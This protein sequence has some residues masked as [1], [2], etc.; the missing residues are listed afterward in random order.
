MCTQYIHASA[1]THTQCRTREPSDI[2]SDGAQYGREQCQHEMESCHLMWS[3]QNTLK[4]KWMRKGEKRTDVPSC[5]ETLRRVYYYF[6]R[7]SY[8]AF[9]LS[10][11]FSNQTECAALLLLWHFVLVFFFLLFSFFHQIS[12]C[13]VQSFAVPVFTVHIY[14]Y[15]YVIMTNK[16]TKTIH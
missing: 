13:S 14:I 4:W 8:M 3:R 10:L 6:I 9:I 1:R 16:N 7:D 15:I 12:F 2:R 5:A 11:L